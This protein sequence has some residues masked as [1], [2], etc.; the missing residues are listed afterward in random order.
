MAYLIVRSEH[1][2]PQKVPLAD[3]PVFIG[4]AADKDVC[5]KD[6]TVSNSH[7]KITREGGRYKIR[8]L[9]STNGTLVNGEEV[10]ERFLS[11]GDEITIGNATI[12]FLDGRDIKPDTPQRQKAAGEAAFADIFT[13]TVAISIDDIDSGVVTPPKVEGDYQALQ[14]KLAV[15]YKLGQSFNQAEGLDA[16][17]SRLTE[18]VGEA[19]GADR[20]FVLLIDPATGDLVPRA[21]G[22]RKAGSAR[23]SGVSSTVVNRVLAE[24]QAIL[25]SDALSDPRLRDAESVALMRLRGVMCVPLVIGEKVCGAIY[26]DSTSAATAFVEDD[27]RLLGAIGNQASVILRNMQLYDDVR[28]TNEELEA[29]RK[30]ILAWNRELE[31]KVRERT[32]EIQ[33][34]AEEIKKLADLKDELLGIT[35]HDLR[36]PLTIIHGYAQLLRMTIQEGIGDPARI[37]EDLK[38]IERTSFE[39]TNLLNDLLDIKTIEAGK[40]KLA[41]ERARPRDLVYDCFNLHHLWARSKGIDLRVRVEEGLPDIVVDPK[42]IAQALNNLVSNAI[43]FSRKGDSIVLAASRTGEGIEFAVEDTGQGIAPEDLLKIFGKYEQSTS[44]K[45][46][47]N[48]RGTGLG[49]AIVKKLVELHGGKIAV[50]SVPGKGSR[51]SFSIPLEAEKAPPENRT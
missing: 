13:K 44:S 37:E 27:L 23:R 18:L 24:K 6:L 41:P 36:T 26:A 45:A 34:Q 39:M 21:A 3:E 2:G 28:R 43:K 31:D 14:R 42:R 9:R 1:E 12:T 35:A 50:K 29:A 30:Q 46:T 7:A 32:A 16:F 49:L 25:T 48:E 8:D 22:G 4:R 19:T 20:V 11:H 47:A 40:I 10:D 5:I 17:L 51:F 33:K 38:T 15:L